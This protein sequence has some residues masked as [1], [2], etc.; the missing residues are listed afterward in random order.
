M[1]RFAGCRGWEFLVML[2]VGWGGKT[3]CK[4]GGWEVVIIFLTSPAPIWGICWWGEVAVC[5]CEGRGGVLWAAAPGRRAWVGRRGV[6]WGIGG[7]VVL[8]EGWRGWGVGVC[9]PWGGVASDRRLSSRNITEPFRVRTP[10]ISCCNGQLVIAMRQGPQWRLP[11]PA[12]HVD[13]LLTLDGTRKLAGSWGRASVPAEQV[14]HFAGSVSR[15]A[16]PAHST[17]V[18]SRSFSTVAK[19]CFASMNSAQAKPVT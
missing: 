16:L 8:G 3:K 14:V 4:M 6:H 19:I 13:A 17:L 2:H 18:R 10:S 5:S 11:R 1:R 12:R 15:R 7:G 9:G